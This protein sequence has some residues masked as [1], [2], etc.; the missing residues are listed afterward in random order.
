[1]VRRYYQRYG[2][3]LA[4]LRITLVDKRER[5]HGSHAVV[6]RLRE[7][8]EPLNRDGINIKVVEV[9]PGPP[10]L[11]NLVAEIYADDL[12]SYEQQQQAATVVMA[13]LRREPF[14]VEVDSTVEDPSS[15]YVIRQQKPPC[16]VL[17][18]RISTPLW[19]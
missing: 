15:A 14:V 18:P 4:D 11:A 13:R 17:P 12:V 10:V 9:P 19:P 2:S 8:L 5:E 1:M 3:N 6:L 16:R 7:L